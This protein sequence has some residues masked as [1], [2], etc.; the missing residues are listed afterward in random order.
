MHIICIFLTI[1]DYIQGFL[2]INGIIW[3]WDPISF[4]INSA[5][6]WIPLWLTAFIWFRCIWAYTT[7]F[8]FYLK[9]FWLFWSCLFVSAYLWSPNASKTYC[10]PVLTTFLC[11]SLGISGRTRC[12]RLWLKSMRCST[13]TMCFPPLLL[14]PRW[15]YP[16][17]Y[18]L[19]SASP[20]RPSHHI[21]G[22]AI[23]S[24]LK[25]T[26]KPYLLCTR[27]NGLPDI[28]KVCC[29]CVRVLLEVFYGVKT[30]VRSC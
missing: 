8:W 11:A 5:I 14:H 9:T 30:S 7:Q 1:L 25:K 2:A 27:R 3:T 17:K 24:I 19:R 23:N 29:C 18:L 13:Y 15:Y 12:Y 28:C 16:A 22:K 21:P 26:L 20:L 4:L 10:S 6:F